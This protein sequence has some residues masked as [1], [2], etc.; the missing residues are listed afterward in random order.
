[1]SIRKGGKSVARII[2][3]PTWLAAVPTV[4]AS[5]AERVHRDEKKEIVTGYSAYIVKMIMQ[6][7]LYA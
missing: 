4:I 2:I 3:C 6:G 7:D 1:M 5:R